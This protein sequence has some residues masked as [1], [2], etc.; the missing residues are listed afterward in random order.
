MLSAAKRLPPARLLGQGRATRILN[1]LLSLQHHPP[2]LFTGPSGVGKRTA[3]LLYAQAANCEN[4]GAVPCGT[5]SAC[6]TI[7]NLR[8]PDIHLFFP[9]S[10][11]RQET[12]SEEALQ[13]ALRETE[14]YVLD[15]CRPAIDPTLV[16]PIDSVRW[17]RGQ[18]ARSPVAARLRVFIIIQANR[19]TIEAANALLKTIEEIPVTTTM[20]LTTDIPEEVPPTIR[21]RCQPVRFGT[22]TADIISAELRR[23]GLMP[24][25]G[26]KQ[27][28]EAAIATGSGSLGLAVRLLENAKRTPETDEQPTITAPEIA[29]R[30]LAQEQLTSTQGGVS[31]LEAEPAEVTEAALQLCT[32]ALR[33]TVGVGQRSGWRQGGWSRDELCRAI[34]FLLELSRESSAHIHPPLALHELAAGLRDCR[35]KNLPNRRG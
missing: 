20:V 10:R 23:R 21:S 8:H 25:D 31:T 26:G 3:A 12:T 9:T 7:I 15:V 19:L 29:A 35:R 27:S 13:E 34:W 11:P 14:S 6:R 16:I 4:E 30:L 33:E 22:L 5:C 1:S 2:L 17:I 24:E 28:P 32:L 18:M